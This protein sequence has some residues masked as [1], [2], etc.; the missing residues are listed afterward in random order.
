MVAEQEMTM[1]RGRKQQDAAS[2]NGS[3]A[4]A[5]VGTR[6]DGMPVEFGGV[7][8]GRKM[9]SVGVKIGREELDI[10]TA[11]EVFTDAQLEVRCVVDPLGNDDTPGQ[12]RFANT[13]LELEGIAI[14]H[15]LGVSKDAYTMRLSFVE[16]SIDQPA[17]LK[18]A[19]RTGHIR[20]KRVGAATSDQIEKANAEVEADD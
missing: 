7:S 11:D 20:A 19:Y 1:P 5:L 15:R 3:A 12:G 18:L 16:D 6:G 10:G 8:C 4:A 14:C 9:M 17:L 2:E 13:D